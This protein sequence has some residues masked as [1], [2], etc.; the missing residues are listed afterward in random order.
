MVTSA[1]GM[2]SSVESAG[3]SAA[4]RGALL[5]AAYLRCEERARSHYENFP[6]VSRFL[7]REG[8]RSLA[9]VYAFARQADDFA[10]EGYGPAGP[11][12][13]ERLAA[14]NGW[15]RRLRAV[16][17]AAPRNGRGQARHPHAPGT[18]A[19]A[20]REKALGADSLS[21]TEMALGWPGPD[22]LNGAGSQTSSGD[23]PGPPGD[24]PGPRG[25]DPG[26]R[27][28]YR[29]RTLLDSPDAEEIFL[30]L[31]DTIRRHSIDPSVFLD[32]LSAFRQDVTVSRYD[33]RADLLDYCRRSANPIGRIVLAVHGASDERRALLSDAICT[34]L[35]LANFWQDAGIDF[36]KDRVYLP[37][38]DRERLGVGEADLAA[39][40]ASAPLRALVL[41]ETEWAR[42]FFLAGRELLADAPQGLG[43]HLR[44]VWHGGLRILDLI[45]AAQGDVLAKRPKL[46]RSDVARLLLRAL[47]RGAAH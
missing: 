39:A 8:R 45:Q 29:L 1:Q 31:G 10:D 9:A 27:G 47:I 35:Q 19:L 34:G 20:A 43:L 24:A 28:H 18:D 26:M 36:A 7:P 17:G 41:E 14:L 4:R 21:A 46:R 44:L 5:E 40:S 13:E 2:S 6:V 22:P 12:P 11:S 16:C 33:T 32:L 23:A 42:S 30:A 3:A 15:E 25:N 38:E 37:L